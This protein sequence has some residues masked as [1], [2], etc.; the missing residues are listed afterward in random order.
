MQGAFDPSA[1]QQHEEGDHHRDGD[2]APMAGAAHDADTGG[3]PDAGGA[4]QA[5]DTEMPLGMKDH[6][7]TEKADA[8]EYAL[9]DPAPGIREAAFAE[10]IGQHHDHRGGQADEPQRAYAHGLAVQIAV[11]A[12]GSANQGGDAQT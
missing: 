5:A 4:G 1:E 9:N 8:G 12:D 11:E 7:G 3:Q 10:R 2:D 6:A